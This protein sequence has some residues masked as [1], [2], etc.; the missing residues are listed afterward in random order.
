M[1]LNEIKTGEIFTIDETPSYP[2]LRTSTGYIDMRDFI[3][4]HVSELPLK[5]SFLRVMTKDEIKKLHNV[6]DDDI[7]GWKQYVIENT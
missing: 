1:T 2:K 5:T 3:E 4:K 6:D 7:E